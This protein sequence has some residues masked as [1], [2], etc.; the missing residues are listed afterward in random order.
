MAL[1]P[2]RIELVKLDRVATQIFGVSWPARG[3][4]W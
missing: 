3:N 2:Q 1:C 4:D